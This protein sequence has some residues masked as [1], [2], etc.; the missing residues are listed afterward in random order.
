MINNVC[1]DGNALTE[2]WNWFRVNSGGK[3]AYAFGSAILNLG[4][5]VVFHMFHIIKVWLAREFIVF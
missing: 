2:H 3:I 5:Q 1:G 4:V